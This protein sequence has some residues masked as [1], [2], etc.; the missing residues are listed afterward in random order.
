MEDD[1][2]FSLN[3]LTKIVTSIQQE[4]QEYRELVAKREAQDLSYK[5]L[6]DKH[7]NIFKSTIAKKEKRIT[8]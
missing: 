8:R 5:A 2:V 7:R 4:M 1:N 3:D 6:L